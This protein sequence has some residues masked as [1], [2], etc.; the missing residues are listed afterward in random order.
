MRILILTQTD[1]RKDAR[2]NRQV[3]WLKDNHEVYTCGKRPVGTEQLFIPSYSRKLYEKILGLLYLLIHA[4]KLYYWDNSRKKFRN[5]LK[6][7][8]FD[9][10]IVHEAIN[11]PMAFALKAKNIILDAHEY[12]PE[13]YGNSFLFN[14]LYKPL[15]DNICKNYIP[16]CYAILT[17]S[18]GIDE[19]YKK[20]FKVQKS[21]IIRNMENY[22]DLKPSDIDPS[23]IKIVHHGIASTSRQL[24]LMIHMMGYLPKNY[25]LYLILISVDKSS[26][27][28]IIRLKKLASANSNILFLDPVEFENLVP[29]LNHFDIGLTLVP[30]INLNL[31]FGLGNK[32]FQFIQARL[33]LAMG[34]LIEMKRITEE[35]NL[36]IVSDDFEPE[37]MA[38]L[39]LNTPIESLKDYKLNAHLHSQELSA[40]ENAQKLINLITEMN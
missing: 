3:N 26:N 10:I 8:E 7:F 32:F 36:G 39:I 16:K 30:P 5:K 12:S 37:T 31:H 25:Y 2:P 1:L 23:K 11:L 27:E 38:K 24:E 6:Q 13:N 35:Y 20:N 34:P 33:A 22:F 29:Y 14:L 4:Y 19:L 28:Y 17:V 15:L 9:V 21:L 18:N 40:K